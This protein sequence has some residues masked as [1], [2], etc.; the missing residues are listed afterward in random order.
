MDD[1]ITY[2]DGSSVVAARYLFTTDEPVGDDCEGLGVDFGS[3]SRAM[4][5]AREVTADWRLTGIHSAEVVAVCA[6]GIARRIW[7]YDLG[8]FAERVD[9]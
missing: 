7:R 5:K 6:E 9:P 2:A 1:L 4:R 8:R 3:K